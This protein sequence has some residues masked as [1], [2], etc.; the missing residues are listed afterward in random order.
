MKINP[1]YK[2]DTPVQYLKGVG[3]KMS[4]KLSK[5][6]IHVLEDLLHYYPRDWEDRRQFCAIRD[7]KPDQEMTLRGKVISVHFTEVRNRLVIFKA[8]ISD[9]TEEL[10]CKWI[11][12]KSFYYDVLKTLKK[13]I[14]PGAVMIAHGKITFDFGGKMM[15]VD[16]YEILTDSEE[17]LIHVNRIVPVYSAMEGIKPRFL[18]KIIHDTLQTAE[19]RDPIPEPVLRSEK[20]SSLQTAL[21]NYHFPENFKE[22]DQARERLAFQELFMIQT[23]LA[24]AKKRRSVSRGF[25]YEIKKH[26]L[27]PFKKKMGFEFTP[28][29]KKVIREIFNDL[30]SDVPMNRLLQGDVGSG[31]TVVACSAM[32]LA[33]E[34]EAQTVLMAPT[35]I[36]AEQHYI[37][38]KHFLESLPVRVGLLT[39]SVKSRERKKFLEECASGKIDIAIGTHALLDEKI[40]LPKCRLIVIDEQHRF[41]VRH[42]LALTQRKPAPDVLV[43]TATPIPRTLA[44]GL[45]GDLEL[46]TIEQLPPGRQ[47][48]STLSQNEAGA[49]QLIKNEI[50]KGR[51]AY[52][53]YPLIDES[54]KV[55][56]KAAIHE[57]EKLKRETFKDFSVGLLHGQMKGAEKEKVM[58]DF[59][60]GRFSI[61]TATTVIEVGIDVPNAT[62]MVIQNAE[63]FGLSTL[64]QLRGRVGRS[65]HPSYCVLVAHPK[66]EEAKRRIEVLLTTSNGFQLAEEDLVLR[67]PGEIFGTL[68]HGIPDLKVADFIRDESLIVKTQKIAR[69]WIHLDPELKKNESFLIR[70]HLR[71]HFSKCWHLA[72]IA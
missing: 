44:L 5:L 60:A 69:E 12:K 38:I 14:I 50:Q 8:L 2:M 15:S 49:Y 19:I 56:L 24:L 35:E 11:R 54:D 4:E 45:Y 48:I 47:K 22:R 66:T 27:T 18:R 61:L 28:S 26:L 23:A 6:G 21:N 46:S 42:R 64:H 71:K 57:F 55:E 43:M 31:K 51:Q 30:A 25:R 63:R 53:V 40:Q 70:E 67:G 36:L 41:G 34:N 20:I 37:T 68:Q 17:D 29:Q 32:L 10:P 39:G 52:I 58:R 9:G 65:H 16:E 13:E 59:H 7:S 3:P 62:V 72:N 33:C 1:H